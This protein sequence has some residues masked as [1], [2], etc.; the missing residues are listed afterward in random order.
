MFRVTRRLNRAPVNRMGRRLRPSP[1]VNLLPPRNKTTILAE[2]NLENYDELQK[3]NSPRNQ[4]SAH[5]RRN[6]SRHGGNRLGAN[7]VRCQEK[8]VG[9][10]EWPARSV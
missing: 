10:Q 7:Q 3:Y 5:F 4:L 2:L 1:L 8:T 9:R 6:F